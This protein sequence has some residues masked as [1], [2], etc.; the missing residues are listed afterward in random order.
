M[1]F[2][3]LLKSHELWVAEHHNLGDEELY[4]EKAR[5][6][7]EFAERSGG[8]AKLGSGVSF[9]FELD[10]FPEDFKKQVQHG[11]FVYPSG[12]H[13]AETMLEINGVG[14]QAECDWKLGKK[15]GRTFDE[16]QKKDEERM[17]QNIEGNPTRV[18]IDS[19]AGESV[20]PVT[21][22]PE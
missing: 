5:K 9:G 12:L 16:D 8:D 1:F 13:L 14:F 2:H 17:I 15:K 11:L 20:C 21:C 6:Q 7:A 10:V 3:V 18:C 4:A 19:G 22:F